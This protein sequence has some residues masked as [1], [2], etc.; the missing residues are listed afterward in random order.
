[1]MTCWTMV[2]EFVFIF[3][4]VDLGA[5][6]FGNGSERRRFFSLVTIFPSGRKRMVIV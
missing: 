1:V 6:A 4:D 3:D 2:G 5:L